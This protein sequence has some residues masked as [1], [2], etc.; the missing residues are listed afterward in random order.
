MIYKPTNLY[1][2]TQRAEDY[3][4]PSTLTEQ[5]SIV[6]NSPFSPNDNDQGAHYL[7]T[8]TS[9]ITYKHLITSKNNATCNSTNNVY[10]LLRC[11]NSSK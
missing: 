8:I 7:Q 3:T 10:K 9:V 2:I 4:I 11:H 5:V 1:S 6:G